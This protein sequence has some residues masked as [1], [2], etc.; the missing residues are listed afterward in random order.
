MNIG[1]TL[2]MPRKVGRF[3]KVHEDNAY[4]LGNLFGDGSYS[5]NSCVTMSI[6]TEEEYEYWNSKYDI[7]ISKLK[8]GYA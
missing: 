4:L 3:G 2:L 6:T 5:D 1:D 8:N 7:N